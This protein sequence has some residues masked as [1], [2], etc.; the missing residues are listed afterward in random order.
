[1]HFRACLFI[2][3]ELSSFTC[4]RFP[5]SSALPKEHTI[6]ISASIL[7]MWS[8]YWW[9]TVEL[10]E[11]LHLDAFLL[12]SF[13]GCWAACSKESWQ[14]C[15]SESP[16]FSAAGY[17]ANRICSLLFFKYV[18]PK[19]GK[20][21]C[22]AWMWWALIAALVFHLESGLLLQLLQSASLGWHSGELCSLD[23]WFV[24]ISNTCSAWTC[25]HFPL[26]LCGVAYHYLNA[27]KQPGCFPRVY[28]CLVCFWIGES[29]T[30]ASASQGIQFVVAF[31][32]HWLLVFVRG[33]FGSR[34]PT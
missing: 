21:F 20:T 30:M 23:R 25:L 34:V 2:W 18:T 22:G 29:E 4:L 32:C 16:A 10:E 19:C 9:S 1:M 5:F 28:A 15:S 3:V 13:L 8:L 26:Y 27:L 31:S 7:K 24:P 17:N 6:S 11:L 14:K 33:V 12:H